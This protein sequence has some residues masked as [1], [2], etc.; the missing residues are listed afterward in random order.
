[1][2]ILKL[3][4]AALVAMFAMA[5]VAT[6]A[7]GLPIVTKTS[8]SGE[9]KLNFESSSITSE[10][11]TTA[12]GLLKG[13]GLKTLLL[14]SGTGSP[15]GTFRADFENVKDGTKKCNSVGDKTATVLTEGSFHLVYTNLSPLLEGILYLP[16]EV[17]IECEGTTSKVKGDILGSV[18]SKRIIGK[19]GTDQPSRQ[20]RKRIKRWQTRDRRILHRRRHESES[21][22]RNHYGWDYQRIKRDCRRRTRV[23]G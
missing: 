2:R 9:L 10:L 21:Q 5:I 13:I 18:K 17:V 23:R 3:A 15:L 12:G 11:E 16:N 4:G 19:H 1:M 22:A 20:A 8:G 14:T 6:S 7:F